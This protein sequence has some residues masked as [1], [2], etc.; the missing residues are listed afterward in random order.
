MIQ[1]PAEDVLTSKATKNLERFKRTGACQELEEDT[2]TWR[3]K[4]WAWTADAPWKWILESS[5]RRLVT[6]TMESNGAYMIR[7]ADPDAA[8]Y[9][10]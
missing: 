7:Y 6:V 9:T 8:G 5:S 1:W 2:H 10:A 4:S 3:V